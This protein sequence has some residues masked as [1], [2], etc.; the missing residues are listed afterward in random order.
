VGFFWLREP[1]K[2]RGFYRETGHFPTPAG[3]GAPGGTAARFKVSA[4]IALKNNRQEPTMKHLPLLTFLAVLS[5]CGKGADQAQAPAAADPSQAAPAA[6]LKAPAGAYQ[7]DPHHTTLEFKLKHMGLADYVMRFAKYDVEL[8][9]DPAKPENSSVSVTIDPTSV[10][11]GYQGDFKA[12]HEGSPY[13]SFEERI[14]REDK[15]LN[16]DKF[17]TITFKSTKVE[18]QGDGYR[19]TGDLAFLGQTHP[20]TLDATVSGS[21]D[22]HPFTQKGAVGFAARTTF[23]R[24]EWGQTGT[25]QFLG[26]AVTVEFYGEFQQADPQAPAPATND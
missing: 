26:D 5:A 7:L 24:S 17:P 22:K 4:L 10:R 8:T 16:S 25:Q 19:V 3:K 20:V 2:R 6:E 23:N 1:P 15:F 18:K 12:T 21:Y 14:A 9:L 13:G 11:T